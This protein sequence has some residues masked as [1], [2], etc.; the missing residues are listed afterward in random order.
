MRGSMQEGQ[1]QCSVHDDKWGWGWAGGMPRWM[2]SRG[3]PCSRTKGFVASGDCARGGGL[4]DGG[5]I[6]GLGTPAGLHICGG[7]QGRSS[8]WKISERGEA[9]KPLNDPTSPGES[10]ACHHDNTPNKRIPQATCF[11]SASAGSAGGGRSLSCAAW[12][13]S[14][15]PSELRRVRARFSNLCAR[16]PCSAALLGAHSHLLTACMHECS[17]HAPAD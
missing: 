14:Y 8:K 15:P 11:R 7:S 3:S 1:R 12:A 4:R 9:H 6:V 16:K 17:L 5:R 2:L 13:A 10:Q